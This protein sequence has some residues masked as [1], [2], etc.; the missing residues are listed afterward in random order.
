V[1]LLVLVVIGVILGF[2]HLEGETSNDSVIKNRDTKT[3]ELNINSHLKMFNL[4]QKEEF[5]MDAF[6]AAG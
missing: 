1:G 6:T 4:N 5:T 2:S 3:K